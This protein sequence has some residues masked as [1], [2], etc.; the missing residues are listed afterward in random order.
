MER[1]SWIPT[2]EILEQIKE[3]IQEGMNQEDIARCVGISSTTFFAKKKEYPE[4]QDAIDEAKAKLNKRVTS[5]L[6]TKVFD[7]KHPNHYQALIFYISKQMW[8]DTTI[9]VQGS[10]KQLPN[11]FDFPVIPPPEDDE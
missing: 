4:I 1:K 10:E 8:K 2:P 5:L 3:M 6:M 9:V 7:E 11:G